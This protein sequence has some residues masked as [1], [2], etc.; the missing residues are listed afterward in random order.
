MDRH[1]SPGTSPFGF[2][3]LR[4]LRF[5]LIVALGFA[6]LNFALTANHPSWQTAAGWGRA[7]GTSLVFAVCIRLTIDLLYQGIARALGVRFLSLTPWQRARG[8]D[9]ELPVSRAYVH[10]F[11]AM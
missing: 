11:K 10:L 3:P 4:S 1:A 9:G 6:L 7:I 5:A 2:R 8:F